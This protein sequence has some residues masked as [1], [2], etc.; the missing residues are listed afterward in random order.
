MADVHALVGRVAQ[1]DAT[2][3]IVGESGTGKEL[4]ATDLHAASRRAGK[5]LVSLD[6]SALAPGLLESELFGHVKGSFTG[7]V[8]TKPGL[9]EVADHGTLF[10]DEVSSLTLEPRKLLRV[11]SLA[12]QS[13][14]VTTRTVDIRLIAA[15]N[16]DLADGP[17]GASGRTCN[18]G[19]TWSRSACHRCASAAPTSSAPALLPREVPRDGPDGPRRFSPAALERLVNIPGPATCGSSERR[20]RLVVT[21][22]GHRSGRAPAG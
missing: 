6:C 5:P 17:G 4:V 12:D 14:G 22:G 2:V 10:L 7:A 1:T 3:L 13:G 11:R 8:A 21:V 15:T 16:R 9:F 19:S 18:T 20:Q